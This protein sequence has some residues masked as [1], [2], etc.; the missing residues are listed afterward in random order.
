MSNAEMTIPEMMAIIEKDPLNI[1]KIDNPP[2]EVQIEA[3]KQNTWA[4]GS[5][6]SPC[7]N[8]KIAAL[9]AWVFSIVYIKELS[10]ETVLKAKININEQSHNGNTPLHYI[11][12]GFI[13]EDKPRGVDM[14]G[15]IELIFQLNVDFDIRDF[16]GK[17]TLELAVENG[18]HGLASLIEG[19]ID[20]TERMASYGR[21]ES[22]SHAFAR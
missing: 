10:L 14:P 3:V 17:T 4:L 5:I 6:K 20:V 18:F 15:R 19:H 11:I 8:A 13:Q 2:E 1:S 22:V 9:Q 7:E 16:D 12:E 21:V